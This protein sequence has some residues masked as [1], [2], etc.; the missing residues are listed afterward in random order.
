M[1]R[2]CAVHH[3]LKQ[4]FPRKNIDAAWVSGNRSRLLPGDGD[5]SLGYDFKLRYDDRWWYLEVKAHMGDPR[6]FD[7][8]ETEVRKARDCA[9]RKTEEYRILYVSNVED[10]AVLHIEVL[11]NP[12]SDV[13]HDHFRVMGEGLRYRFTRA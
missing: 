9:R 3:W 10:P 7:L 6:E 8:G 2:E 12:L 4:Q 13:H 11:P 1:K 5:D